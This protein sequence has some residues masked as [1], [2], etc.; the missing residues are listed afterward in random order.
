MLFFHWGS[1]AVSNFES[2]FSS[3]ILIGSD[4]GIF[5]V[6]G[7]HNVLPLSLQQFCLF[8]CSL[9]HYIYHCLEMDEFIITLLWYRQITSILKLTHH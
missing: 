1:V 4:L 2:D 3:Y 7:L 5:V 6:C 8:V 9:S